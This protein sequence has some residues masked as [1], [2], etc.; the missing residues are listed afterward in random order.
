MRGGDDN[1]D[2]KRLVDEQPNMKLGDRRMRR[3]RES[4]RFDMERMRS[5]G[6]INEN[7]KDNYD[8]AEKKSIS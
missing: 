1:N 4:V 2:L 3:R 5:L 8:D 7:F 6:E